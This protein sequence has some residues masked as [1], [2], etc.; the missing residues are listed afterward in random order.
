MPSNAFMIT[1]SF[2][3]ILCSNPN[4]SRKSLVADGPDPV[5]FCLSSCTVHRA[6]V[7]P[8]SGQGVG[9]NAKGSSRGSYEFH[10]RVQFAELGWKE[11]LLLMAKPAG[12]VFGS[13]IDT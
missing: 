11:T 13:V 4:F 1:P 7:N 5:L 3:T 9:G 10:F 12:I 2:S 6:V 8:E